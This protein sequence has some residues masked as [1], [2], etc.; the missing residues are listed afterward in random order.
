MIKKD[1]TLR[2]CIG[3][4]QL[5]KVTINNKYPFPRIDD[6]FDQL[7]GSSFFSK[8]DLRLGYHQ[9]RVRDGDIPTIDFGTHYGHYKFLVMSVGL[10]N[11]H[12]A[13]IDLINGVFHEYLDSLVIVIIDDILIFSKTKEE[14][15]KHMRLTLQVPRQHLLY[16]KFSKCE[17]MLRLVT[18]LGHVIPFKGVEVNVSKSEVVKN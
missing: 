2:I 6:L 18:F 16:A 13:F 7:Q 9:L 1:G 11:A 4:R 14:H 15:E 10:T 3:Y 12:A 8:F 17:F 5:N